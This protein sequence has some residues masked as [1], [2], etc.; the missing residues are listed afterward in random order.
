[1]KRAAIEMRRKSVGVV[2][3]RPEGERAVHKPPLRPDADERP[4]TTETVFRAPGM[5]I[6]LKYETLR[7]GKK[8]GWIDTTRES[9]E[10]A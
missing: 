8:H 4:A 5:E 2:R 10:S 7:K 9:S 3:E 1:V 6:R